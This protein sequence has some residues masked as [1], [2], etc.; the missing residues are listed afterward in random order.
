M[1]GRV[2]I[3]FLA[4]A[5]PLRMCSAQAAQ[6]RYS[7]TISPVNP[8]AKVGSEFR[9]K[10]VQTNT[11]GE[12]Q[13]FWLDANAPRHG[14]Y[15]Y[16][17]DAWLSDGR[18]APRSKYFREVRDD[19]GKLRGGTGGSAVMIRKKPGESIVSSIDLNE[20]YDLQPGEYTVQVYQKDSIAKTTVKSNIITVTVVP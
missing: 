19:T 13:Y 14:E 6:P 15:L 5:T 9:V 17:I 16:R 1:V 18:S 3:L 2:L 11:S 7:I 20:L 4:A 8:T 12:N 10:I